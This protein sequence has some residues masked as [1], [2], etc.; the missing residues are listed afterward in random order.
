MAHF[1]WYAFPVCLGLVGH[2]MLSSSF[3]DKKTAGRSLRLATV[4]SCIWLSAFATY[5]IKLQGGS[6]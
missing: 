4:S 1:L 3:T 6:D 2:A 5:L